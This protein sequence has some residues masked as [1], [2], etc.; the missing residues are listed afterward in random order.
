[1]YTECKS[2]TATNATK[3]L[4]FPKSKLWRARI[5][6]R[7]LAH[8]LNS[9]E[10]RRLHKAIVD[11]L[12]R[13]LECCRNPAPD[14]HDSKWWFQVLECILRVYGREGKSR[15]RCGKPVRRIERGGRSTY[16]CGPCQQ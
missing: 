13:A 11:V 5:D 3:C 9:V 7:R 12:Q 15:R 6:P 16:F 1:L 8:R 10:T 4:N 2:R 14:F